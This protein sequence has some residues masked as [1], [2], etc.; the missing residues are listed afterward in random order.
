MR[1]SG[2]PFC[3]GEAGDLAQR[4]ARL[5][6]HGAAVLVL[7]RD[8]HDVR[9]KVG[10]PG[11]YYAGSHGFDIIGPDGTPVRGDDKLDFARYL[12]SLEE[13]STMLEQRLAAVTGSQVERKKYAIAIH[14]RRV[15][16]RVPEHASVARR[17]LE[18]QRAK[19]EKGWLYLKEKA[20]ATELGARLLA[21]LERE[22]EAL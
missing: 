16:E 11:I 1:T 8:V 12:P 7:G 21:E 15:A 13:A 17:M 22:V 19:V 5:L 6:R 4:H 3:H 20:R 10:V 9:D 18:I 14:Y 2:A